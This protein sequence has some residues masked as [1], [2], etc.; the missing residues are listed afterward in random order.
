MSDQLALCYH[1]VSPTWPERASVTPD[2]L[3][4]HV[5]WLLRRGYRAATFAETVAGGGG[6][7]RVVALTFDDGYR[8]VHREA[9]PLLRALGVVGTAF[10]CPDLVGRPLPLASPEWNGGPHE[11]ELEAMDWVEL[12]ELAEAG[13]EIGS[14][15][16]THPMLTQLG[17]AELARQLRD[18]R[19]AIEDRLGRPCRT[20]AYP[21]GDADARVA[22]AARDAGYAAAC[23]LYP[24]YV[25]DPSRWQMPRVAISHHHGG[26][27]RF[28]A[29][30]AP[31]TRRLRASRRAARLSA[32]V[33]R[34]RKGLTPPRPPEPLP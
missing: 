15:T 30:A 25:R 18:S 2:S 13:W 9:L 5:R 21:Y 12:A 24:G 17:D 29:K 22:A 19:A 31:S 34:R 26:G 33:Y 32:P 4:R 14:H 16:S 28:R 11:G 1:A 6:G 20:L 7:G 27:W 8:S 10:V 3:E 23:T